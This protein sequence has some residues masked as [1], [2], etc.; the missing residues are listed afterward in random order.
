MKRNF[1]TRLIIALT[2][3]YYRASPMWFKVLQ[4]CETGSIDWAQT[5]AS[6]SSTK[7]L[8]TPAALLEVI[9]SGA[10]GHAH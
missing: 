2:N 8:K 3:T 6:G 4:T 1:M 9:E 10:G 5:P 7:G